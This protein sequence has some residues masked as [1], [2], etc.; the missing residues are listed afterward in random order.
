MSQLLTADTVRLYLTE[1]GKTPLLTRAEEVALARD[2]EEAGAELRRVVLGSPVAMRQVK[3]WADLIACRQM[4]AKELMPRGSPS[5]P[6]IAAFGRKIRA[7]S[8][9]LN[10][11]GGRAEIG[12]KLIKLG[13]HDEKIRRLGNRIS[14]QA[15][16]LEQGL[17]TDPLPMPRGELLALDIQVSA[18]RDRID[19]SKVKLLRANLRL[20]VS[21]AKTRA[22][23]NMELADLIQEGSLGLIR[24]AEK[25]RYTKGFRFSTYAT[26][27]I[28]QS[29]NR[30]I[31]DQDRTIRLPSNVREEIARFKHAG[32]E[33]MQEHGRYPGVEEYARRLRMPKAKV[34]ELMTAMQLP[35]SLATPV[36]EEAD[37]S[38]EDNLK[39]HTV[40]EPH[41][42]GG[43]MLRKDEV[44][45]WISTL[46]KREAGVLTMRFG[47]DGGS[48][49]S[50]DEVGRVFH[51]TRER[52]RQI[53][54]Q[55]LDKLRAGPGAE[56]LR[57]YWN[58][59]V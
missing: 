46:E 52:A 23:D 37:F 53:Q 15:R 43:A 4:S 2:I 35:L 11:R 38:L 3:I 58:P 26:W 8:A 28:R 18:L 48:P 33:Y 1:L 41:A 17:P 50:L 13:L 36:G 30:A 6:Q 20:V 27:W 34:S 39:D 7:L 56:R 44:W 45:K 5:N 12:A 9:G 25:F 21:I 42:H 24:A 14:D 16:R 49:R 54:A 40:P 47:L 19:E 31:A 22:A 10:R 59:G 51:V 57:D 55:A 29:I 32:R